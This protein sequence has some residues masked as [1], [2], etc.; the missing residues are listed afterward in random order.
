MKKHLSG[1][2]VIISLLIASSSF[3]TPIPYW[4]LTSNNAEF[5]LYDGDQYLELGIFEVDDWT[6][7]DPTI[8]TQQTLFPANTPPLA[9]FQIYRPGT[10]NGV[11]EYDVFGFYVHNTNN[12]RYWYSDTSLGLNY[13]SQ[14]DRL[15]FV[16]N[17][18]LNGALVAN[19]WDISFTKTDGTTVRLASVGNDIAPVPEPGTIFLLGTGFLGLCGLG[20]RRKKSKS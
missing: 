18:D 5:T 15:N 6:N 12:G 10:N 4:S 13:H 16:K 1:L 3:A 17:Y 7:P 14:F 11:Q 19:S 2:I 8:V 9:Y 20:Y